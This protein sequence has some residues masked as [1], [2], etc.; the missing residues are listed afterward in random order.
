MMVLLL[1][2]MS[3]VAVTNVVGALYI[4]GV[5]VLARLRGSV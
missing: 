1:F 2:S 4:V 3:F 5:A